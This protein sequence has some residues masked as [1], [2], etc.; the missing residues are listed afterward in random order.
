[1]TEELHKITGGLLVIRRV[2]YFS[3]SRYGAK[4]RLSSINLSHEEII[5]CYRGIEGEPW[6]IRDEFTANNISKGIVPLS[7]LPNVIE[8]Y[9]SASM[10][11]LCDLICIV[12]NQGPD[13]LI[14]A[15]N[16]FIFCGFD[17]G[18]YESEGNCFSS[19][20]NEIIY[21]KYEELRQF[22]EHLNSALLLPNEDLLV[23]FCKSRN[24][25]VQLGAD[26]ETT[27]HAEAFSSISIFCMQD[28]S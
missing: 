15:F 25:M 13:E 11:C 27:D 12:I 7:M 10:S 28:A 3:D 26:L 2:N 24:R 17:Y 16:N 1:M 18:I 21:G 22:G 20:F 19:V 23:D 14:K 4:E 9:R 8:Y 6:P 5:K